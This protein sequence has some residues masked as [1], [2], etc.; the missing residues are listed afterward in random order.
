MATADRAH[1]AARRHVHAALFGILSEVGYLVEA[2]PADALGAL[3]VRAG[4]IS[5]PTTLTADIKRILADLHDN[6]EG[7]RV[8][9]LSP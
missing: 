1:E 5:T 3:T 8:P 2:G 7:P 4:R 9:G 6:P